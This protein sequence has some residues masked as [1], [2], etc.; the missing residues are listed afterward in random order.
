VV[1]SAG[2][3]HVVAADPVE[4]V[5]DTTGAGDA[6]AAGVLYGLT[7]GLDL[8]TCGRLG[9]VGAAEVISHLG[10]RPEASLAERAAAVLQG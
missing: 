7:H 1:V 2:T 5:I 10:P 4:M 3:Q 6:Y 9:S 8:A